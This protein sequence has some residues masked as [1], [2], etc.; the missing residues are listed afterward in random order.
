V[1]FQYLF[2]APF[3][4]AVASI[5]WRFLRNGSLTGA[6][7]G[8]RISR[9]VGEIPIATGTASSTVLR[10]HTMQSSD[11]ELFVG[12]V[13]VSKAPLGARMVPIKLSKAQTRHLVALLTQA[14]A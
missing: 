10:V 3:A 8:G 4:F 13:L 7:L 11:G 6:L 1:K 5:G 2:F 12:L 14:S 9:E